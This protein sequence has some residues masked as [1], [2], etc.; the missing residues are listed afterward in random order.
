MTVEAIGRGWRGAL[1]SLIQGATEDLTLACPFIRAHEAEWVARRL[2]PAVRVSV[3][4]NVSAA[5]VADG[6]LEIAALQT[7]G[8]R[9]ATITTLPGLHAK[10]FIDGSRAAIVGSGNLTSAGLDSN[11]EYGL[12]VSDRALVIKIREDLRRYC[13]L[14]N[15]LDPEVLSELATAGDALV[16]QRRQ[17]D[18][19]IPR[20]TRDQFN[21]AL[22]EARETFAGAQVGRRTANEL[23]SVAIRLV[24]ETGP[25]RTAE[26]HTIV[27]SLLPELCDDSEE[28][29]INGERFG[30]AWKHRL[31]NAQQYLKRRGE[32]RY[33]SATRRWFL[34]R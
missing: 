20:A 7:L 1:D 5:S 16:E 9:N 4:T 8:A 23:F 12:A 28:L 10:V 3:L 14:G 33:E 11:F 31:R 25:R 21:R 32:L 15:V 22:R 24:L 27:Q 17:L 6:V 19:S 13:E 30:K 34:E 18:R 29:V 26:L 2:H